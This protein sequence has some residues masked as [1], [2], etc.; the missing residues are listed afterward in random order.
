MKISMPSK[1]HRSIGRPRPVTQADIDH[2]VAARAAGEQVVRERG[3][4][5]PTLTADNAG[6][7][8]AWQ[9]ERL[10]E[11]MAPIDARWHDSSKARR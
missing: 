7:A 6:E 1:F 3:A 8:M 2:R 4:K 10:R 11:L 9:E 5:F